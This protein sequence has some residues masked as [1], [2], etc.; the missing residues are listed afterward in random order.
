MFPVLVFSELNLLLNTCTYVFLGSGDVG[1][2]KQGKPQ[3]Q[4]TSLLGVV[5]ICGLD[6]DLKGP[7]VLVEGKW[8]TGPEHRRTTPP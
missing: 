1:K 4:V 8:E 7:L 5:W 2:W 3:S 6:L